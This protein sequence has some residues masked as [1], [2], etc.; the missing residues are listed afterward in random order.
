MQLRKSNKK[1]S[2][3]CFCNTKNLEKIVSPKKIFLTNCYRLKIFREKVRRAK[4]KFGR[5]RTA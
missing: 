5:I 1:F 3:N 2:E 4:K